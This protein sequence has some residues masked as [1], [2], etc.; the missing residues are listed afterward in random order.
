MVLGCG[1]GCAVHCTLINSL[2]AIPGM[3]Q[4]HWIQLVPIGLDIAYSVLVDERHKEQV[5]VQCR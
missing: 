5:K 2:G 3:S 4:L 1:F